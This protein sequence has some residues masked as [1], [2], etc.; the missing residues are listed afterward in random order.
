MTPVKVNK[1]SVQIVFPPVKIK[2]TT[3]NYQQVVEFFLLT[4]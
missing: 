3:A 1:P 4:N 2:S